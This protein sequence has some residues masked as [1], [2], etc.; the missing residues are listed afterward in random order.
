MMNHKR[1]KFYTRAVVTL[2][3]N[4][5]MTNDFIFYQ[6][7]MDSLYLHFS[8]HFGD[9][10]ADSVESNKY[11]IENKESVFSNYV[12]TEHDYRIWI[13]TNPGHDVTTILFPDE[14]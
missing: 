7:V 10:S 5:K 6:F 9:I 12:D 11:G 4:E 14:Y 13:I 2:G 8:G 3:V 1:F